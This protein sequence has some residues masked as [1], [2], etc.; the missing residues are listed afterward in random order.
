MRVL[1]VTPESDDVVSI[2]VGGQHLEELHAESGQ[3]FRWRFLTPDHWWTAHP[4]SLSASPTPTTLRLTV[5]AL[6]DGTRKLQH[7]APGR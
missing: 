7:L 2:L 6:G 3:F 1:K 5:K 4:F